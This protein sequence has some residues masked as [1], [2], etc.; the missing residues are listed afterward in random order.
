MGTF[1]RS[2]PVDVDGESRLRSAVPILPREPSESESVTMPVRALLPADSPRLTGENMEH[3]RLL[4]ESEAPL[5]PILVHRR[6]RKIIDGMHRLRAAMLRGEETIRVRMFDGS[7][8]AAFILAVRA[9]VAHGLPLSLADREAAAGRILRSEPRW[10]DR[11]IGSITGLSSKTIGV[12]R[13][14]VLGD[15]PGAESRIGRDGRVRP[16]NCDEGRRRA[17]EL[18]TARPGASLREVAREA[19]VSLGTA[20]DVRQRL[21]RGE[22]PVPSRQRGN[23]SPRETHTVEQQLRR[24]ASAIRIDRTRDRETILANLRRDPSIRFTESGRDLLRW[25]E[26]HVTG[27]EDLEKF[28]ELLAPHCA[29]VMADLACAVA[30]EWLQ[31]AEGL[32]RRT[33]ASG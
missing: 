3:V 20:R 17:G 11:V 33:D 27:V 24:T 6:T 29:Y 9:N 16:L 8:E 7:D 2:V 14:R 18:F 5:P 22:D 30:D 32:R 31:V 15:A 13:R 23:R 25:L 19:G 12:I 28:A 4:A 21:Q 1:A 10:S 26:Q